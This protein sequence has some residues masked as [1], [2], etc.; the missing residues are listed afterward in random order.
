MIL[1]PFKVVTQEPDTF[2]PM[3]QI[4]A[5]SPLAID[6]C[7]DLAE[8]LVIRTGQEKDPHLERQC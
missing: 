3:D 7:R 1:D 6:D 4:E 8:G 5:D 2:N